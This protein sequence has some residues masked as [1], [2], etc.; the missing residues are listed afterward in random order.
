[1]F[2]LP[3]SPTRLG[4]SFITLRAMQ[5]LNW[6]QAPWFK[7]FIVLVISFAFY[8]LA[9]DTHTHRVAKYHDL[10]AASNSIAHPGGKSRLVQTLEGNE[11]RYRYTIVARG[12]FI[13]KSGGR[14]IPAFPPPRGVASTFGG[15]VLWDMFIPSFTCPFPMYRV[16]TLADGGK[17]VCGLERVMHNRPNCIVYSLGYQTPASSSFEQDVLR[18]SSGCQVYGF[19]VNAMEGAPTTWPW[20]GIVSDRS[21]VHF[22]D[23]S[24]ANRTADTY[25]SLYSVM[26]EFGHDFVDILKVDL[27]GS[28]FATLVSIIAD[29][30]GEPLPFGQLLVKVHIGRSPDMT[31]VDH[32]GQWFEKL[33]WAGLRPYYFEISMLDVN[34]QRAA[35]AVGYW[36][37]MNIRGEH[38]LLDDGLPEYP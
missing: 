24:V 18:S 34:T 33:E 36:S 23:F 9:R 37:F 11:R 12:K 3:S 38:A 31:T 15:Y 13:E 16:G 26:W 17:W 35:P 20:G 2:A 6:K 32:F 29:S 4:A 25:R 19:D 1:M 10:L 8:L 22:N 14:H 28:E 30:E 5:H 21:R 7:F 27:E